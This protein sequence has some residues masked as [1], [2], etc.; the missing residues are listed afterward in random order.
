MAEKKAAKKE[1]K[2]EQDPATKLANFVVSDLKKAMTGAI[3]KQSTYVEELMSA[4]TKKAKEVA[5]KGEKGKEK[6]APMTPIEAIRKALE[7][8]Q[9][10][11]PDASIWND[12]VDQVKQKIA[13]DNTL[14]QQ[15]KDDLNLYL[16]EYTSF[17]YD[18]MLNDSVIFKAI[19]ENLI[20][21]GYG[22]GNT[23]NFRALI[24]EGNKAEMFERQRLI[25]KIK[26]DLA[27]YDPV[28]V[29]KIHD[30]VAERYQK[31]I[32]EKRKEIANAHIDKLM[33]GKSEKAKRAVR[34]KIGQLLME[35]RMRIS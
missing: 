18:N 25:E 13:E 31:L 33:Q 19:K 24:T 1:E 35:N 15:D 27:Q 21:N 11:S 12:A 22:K 3:H 9:N 5:L 8:I 4:L 23:A 6:A 10:G 7:A 30:I 14:S 28:Q 32:N 34:G 16:N 26:N 29:E 17:V 20:A 2:E